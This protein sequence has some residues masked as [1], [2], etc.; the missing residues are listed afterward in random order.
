MMVNLL[1]GRGT[2]ESQGI[3]ALRKRFDSPIG[4]A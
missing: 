4:M 2:V 1:L 3:L